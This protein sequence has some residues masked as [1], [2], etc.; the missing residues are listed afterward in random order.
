MSDKTDA[1]VSRGKVTGKKTS[2]YIIYSVY[3]DNH[4]IV[5][6]K[7][8]W[9]KRAQYTLIPLI[10]IEMLCINRHFKI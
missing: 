1:S 5:A 9:T 7:T 10:G 2:L 3:I 8:R 4:Y 6:I